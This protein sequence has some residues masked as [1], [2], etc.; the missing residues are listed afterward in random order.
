MA[1]NE[2]SYGFNVPFLDTLK[3][4]SQYAPLITQVKTIAAAENAYDR[5][6]AVVDALQWAASKSERTQ[7]DDEAVDHLEAIL[8]TPEGKAFFDWIVATVG[9]A[10]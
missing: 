8:K 5:A 9:A 1:R 4:L 2:E 10:L 7:V 3:L 6:L